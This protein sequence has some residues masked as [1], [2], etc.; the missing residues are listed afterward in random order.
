MFKFI[1]LFIDKVTMYRLV[2]YYLIVLIVVAVGLALFGDLH[3]KPQFI[4]ISTLIL[5]ATCWTV[6]KVLAYIFDAP[7][8]SE[9]SIIT[10]LILTLIITPNP[11]GFGILFLLA[12]SGLAM[13]SKYILTIGKKHVFNPTAIAVVL[14]ALGPRQS[15]SWW[16]GTA[17]MLP[18]VVIGGLL[19]ARKIHRG[20]MIASFLASASAATIVYAL[21]TK[22][23]IGS[24]LHNIVLGSPLLF[25][26]FVM[27][28]EPLTSPVTAK[29]QTWYAAIV[30]VLLPPQVH[31]F[32]FYASPEL[33]L[34]AGNVYAYVVS[35]KI[36][37]FPVLKEKVAIAANTL[38][39][40]FKPNQRLVFEPGQYME[41]T[42]PHHQTDS[43]GNRRYFT[44]ASSPTESDLHIGVKFYANGSSFKRAMQHLGQ[45]STIVA[46]QIA[47]DFV[48]PKDPKQKLVFIAGGIGIT[49]F[50][51]MAKFLI[52]T[53]QRRNITLLYS[54]KTEADL[55]YRDIFKEAERVVGIKTI[56]TLTGHK[57]VSAKSNVQVGAINSRLIK[58]AV[59]DYAERIFYISGTPAMVQAMGTI[60]LELGVSRRHIKVDFFPGYS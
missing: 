41:W 32:N 54:A 48:L 15:A 25:L 50:R 38:D 11:T 23:S 34:I 20:N 12:V 33:A 5:V 49:P 26:G 57:A 4:V 44:L 9:S 3:Y 2:L 28:T 47:G 39:F 29:K 7:T 18:F 36:K 45:D 16:V 6:N 60:L 27:L 59:S 31:I 58:V 17:V 42:L 24:N 21:L 10:G 22:A 37:L 46:S 40:V 55:A 35:P 53:K 19:I 56:Y 52:D 51:S 1:D 43:R 14:T 13:A 30:G 8:G